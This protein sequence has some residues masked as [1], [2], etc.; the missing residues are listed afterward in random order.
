M[1]YQNNILIFERDLNRECCSY[2]WG[3]GIIR[4]KKLYMKTLEQ[5]NE[6]NILRKRISDMLDD[7]N[8]YMIHDYIVENPEIFED[9]EEK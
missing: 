7:K 8:N 3:R 5:E 4:A 6:I 1:N 2:G 9:A